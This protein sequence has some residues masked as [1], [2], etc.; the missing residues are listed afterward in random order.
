MATGVKTYDAA[1]GVD[2]DGNPV[3]NTLELAEQ[4]GKATGV[5]TAVEW[6]HATPAGF[7]AHNESRNDYAGIGVEMVNVSAADVIISTPIP[8]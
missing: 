4:K 3:P 6:S 2:V 8:A 1:I 5:V 7:V